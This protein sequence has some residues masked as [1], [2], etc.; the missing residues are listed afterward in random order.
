[1]DRRAFSLVELL[2]VVAILAV[3][4]ALLFPVFARS[5]ER[6]KLADC[7]TRLHGFA[8]ALSL[9]RADHDDRGF[10]W[11]SHADGH[12]H[13]RYPYNW[14]EPMGGY[15]GDGSVLWCPEPNAAPEG[16]SWQLYNYRTGVERRMNEPG[17]TFHVPFRPVP[18]LVV[19]Y[20]GNHTRN[21][22]DPRAQANL[23]QGRYPF[24]REDTSMAIASSEAI[25]LGYYDAGGWYDKPGGHRTEILRFPGESWPPVPD[26]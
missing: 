22:V 20:C 7:G 16:S 11:V 23:R 3:L 26:E 19:A 25:R 15:L 10:V 6:A 14:F 17:L 8:A 5:K 4:A 21:A 13:N 9:Y 1:M 24:V 2:V 12:N 18:G